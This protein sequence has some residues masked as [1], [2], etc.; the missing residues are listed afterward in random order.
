MCQLSHEEQLDII[1]KF[2]QAS[3]EGHDDEAS[4]IIRQLPLAPEVAIAVR[5][6]LGV[7]YL[8]ALKFD[9]SEAEAVYGKNW[10]NQ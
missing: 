9:L 8:K 10:L 3:E 1:S 2:I 6:V 7:E 4:K 5:D